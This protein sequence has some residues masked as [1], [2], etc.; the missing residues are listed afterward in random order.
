MSFFNKIF[1]TSKLSDAADMSALVT[2]VHSH[3]IPGIDDGAKT[4]DDSLE[5]I[6][7]MSEL[8]YRKVITTPHIMSDH[9]RNTP[10]NILA[11]LEKVREAVLREK[12]DIKVDAA[13]EYYLDSEFDQKIEG[14]KLLTFGKNYVLF[15]LSF[16]SPPEILFDIIF[17]LQTHGYIPV[18]AH[19]E[20]YSYWYGNLEQFKLIKERGALLQL[21]INS[22]TG[23]Y[24]AECKKTAE[25]LI[26]N[27]M[28]NFLGSD[29]HH[30]GHIDLINKARFAKHLHKLLESGLLLNATL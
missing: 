9:Y 6:R 7:S 10:E 30:T 19:P 29:C 15:E 4:M 1:S 2:D 20:R 28:V 25:K 21:N 13:A 5:L 12:I 24:S 8:G 11:G 14:R 23:H 17:K 18:L 27:N 26:D 22:I 16:F 3:F